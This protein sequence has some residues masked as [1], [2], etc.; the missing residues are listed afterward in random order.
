MRVELE[1]TVDLREGIGE[2]LSTDSPG[3]QRCFCVSPIHLRTYFGRWVCL[4]GGLL[5]R[6]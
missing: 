6:P 4:C 1:M 2:A 5:E 3:E